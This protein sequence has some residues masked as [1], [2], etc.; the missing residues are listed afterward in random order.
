VTPT[1]RLAAWLVT[2][3]VGHFWSAAA[4]ITLLWVRYGWARA[5]RRP[6]PG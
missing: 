3:P 2:G 4:D 1:D 5:T 6:P